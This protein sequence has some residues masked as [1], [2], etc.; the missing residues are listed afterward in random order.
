M[1]GNWK[2][3]DRKFAAGASKSPQHQGKNK[4]GQS[5]PQ[6]PSHNQHSRSGSGT[7]TSSFSGTSKTPPKRWLRWPSWHV[8]AVLVVLVFGGVGYTATTMLLKLPEQSNCRAVFWPLASASKRLYCAQVRAEGQTAE[9]LLA[10][11]ELI[12]GLPNDNPMRQQSD[13]YLQQWSQQILELAEQKFQA[14]KLE[15]AITTARQIPDHTEANQLVQQKVNRWQSIWSQAEELE[16]EIDQKL[17]QS[18]FNQAFQVAIKLTNVGNDYWATTQYEKAV[19]RIKVAQEDKKK[20][21]QAQENFEQGGLK[22]WQNTLK[23]A[24]QIQSNSYFYQEAQTLLNQTSDRLLKNARQEIENENW[25]KVMKIAQAI[26]PSLDLQEQV[27][28]LE[29][30]AFAG[31]NSA[32]ETVSGLEMAITQAKRIESERPLHQ[33]AQQLIERWELEAKGLKHL[34]KARQLALSGEVEDLKGAIDQA[35]EIAE[36]N[37]YYQEAQQEISNWTRRIQVIQDQPILNRANQLANY[38]D[39]E[40]LREAIAEASKIESGRALSQEAQNKIQEWR[41]RIQVIEDQP[42]LERANQ[43]ASYSSVSALRDAI[44]EASKIESGRALYEEAQ[45]NIQ[46]WRSRIQVI[47]DQ[48]LLNRARQL[49]SYGNVEDLREAITQASKID[50][51][52]A[53]YEEAQNKIQDW[54]ARIQRIQDQPLLSNAVTLANAERFEAAIEAAQEIEQG[55]ALYEEAQ[56]KIRSWRQEIQ[57]RENLQ[58][59]RQTARERTPEALAKAIRTARKVPSETTVREESTSAIEKWS[60]RLLAIARDRADTNLRKAIEVAQMI[61][62]GTPAYAAARVEIEDWKQQLQPSE[63]NTESSPVSENDFLVE[64]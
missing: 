13:R 12:N 2:M 60:D 53:L 57:A 62:S 44:N 55:R 43:L 9:D 46:D 21:V 50:S 52:R 7:A 1:T 14:G 40:A 20:L 8:W 26:P 28:D 39:V 16:A 18:K 19:D 27:T 33:K 17:R 59:A 3:P 51:N 58:Q 22:N 23:L 15:E 10:A 29:N 61:P 30:L 42:I 4:N 38:G 32:S 47:E 35:S 31:M 45:N 34:S 48:P 41:S 64:P 54:R 56:S 5:S 37:P 36:S 6:K 49:A 11:I 24:G 63:E 25:Q